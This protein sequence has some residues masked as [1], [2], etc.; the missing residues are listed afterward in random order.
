MGSEIRQKL[1]DGI[2]QMSIDV[3]ILLDSGLGGLDSIPSDLW[4]LIQ[5]RHEISVFRDLHPVD[6]WS[7][8]GSS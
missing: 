5:T 4:N 6:G 7:R 3:I 2:I 8:G 1:F